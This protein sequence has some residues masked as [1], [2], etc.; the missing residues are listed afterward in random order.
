[1]HQYEKKVLKAMLMHSS[2]PTLAEHTCLPPDA[3]TRALYWLEEKKLVEID[4]KKEISY[5]PTDEC[6]T[7]IKHGFPEYK[8][9]KKAESGAALQDLSEADKKIGLSWA[10]KNGWVKVE[11]GNLVLLEEGKKAA[12]RDMLAES[13]RPLLE[14]GKPDEKTIETLKKRNLVEEKEKKKLSPSLT[15]EGARQAEKVEVKDEVNQLTKDMIVSGK[16]KEADIRPYDIKAPGEDLYPGKRHLLM[17]MAEKVKRI[18]AE[19]GF[20][21]MEGPIIESSFWTFDALFQPQDH[22]ARELADTF[23]MKE[24]SKLPPKTLVK[25]VKKAHEEGWGYNWDEEEAGKTVLRTH[26]TAVSARALS[27]LDPKTPKKFFCV[28]RVYRNESIDFK[29]LAEFYQVEGIVAWENATFRDLLGLL[30]EFYK[31]LGFE[32]IRFRP[33]YFP[34]TEPSLEVEV[35]FEEKKEWMELGGAGI[36]RP[37]VTVPLCGR[38]PVLAWGLSLERPL[39]LMKNINDIR[40]FYRNDIDWLRNAS[41]ED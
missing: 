18:F 39:M 19:M 28:G 9:A 16:W 30:K 2:V 7:Y 33:S 21:E 8:V 24:K 4:E 34:Y 10:I 40:T 32:K 15:K 26:T 27:E 1:M 36:L 3:V 41:L 14:G 31:R 5:A 17:R 13:S 29:H 37:E 11:N 22:P 12:E 38:Y 25:K 35:Y 20:E 6:I 23:Y